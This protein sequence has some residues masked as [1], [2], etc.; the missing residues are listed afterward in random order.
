M[1]FNSTPFVVFFTCFFI[2]YWVVLK[3]KALHFKNLLILAGCYVFYGWW[4]LAFSFLA[5]R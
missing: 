1:I 2:L 4:E 3:K 5:H